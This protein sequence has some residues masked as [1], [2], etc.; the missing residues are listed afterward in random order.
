MA[1]AVGA[2]AA[3]L[4][5]A[6]GRLPLV[7]M[8]E[9]K[10]YDQRVRWAA[11]PAKASQ[12]IVMVTIDEVSV[13]RLD[14]LVGRWPWPRLVHADVI[15]FLA[16]AGARTI[17]FDVLFTERDR[18]TGF[19][20]GSTIW[21]GQESDRAFAASVAKAGNVV[22]LADATFEGLVG[23]PKG[24]PP[25]SGPFEARPDV[26]LPYDEL[27]RAARLIGHNYF[28]LDS[29][30]PVRRAVTFIDHGGRLVPSLS[31]A[32]WMVAASLDPASARPGGRGVIVGSHDIPLVTD[33]LPAFDKREPRRT[34]R[35][36]LIDFRGPAV[37]EDGRR[38][39]YKQYS[40]Y[41]LFY[42]R[43]EQL[44]GAAPSISPALFR[45]KIVVIGT[46]AAGLHDVFAV[47]FSSGG[48][49]PGPQIHASVID[50]LLSSRF[51]EPAPK[52]LGTTLMV[53]ASIVT[54]FLIVFLPL[55]WAGP[56]AL[57]LLST[58]VAVAFQAFTHGEWWPLAQ[59]GIAWITA[60]VGGLGYQ[61]FVEGRDKRAV[62]RLF[63]RYLSPDVYALVLA[64]PALAELGG[65]RRHMTV[66]FSD[67]RGFT[68]MTERGQ[69]EAVV[70]Q[71]N[72]YF[73]AMVDVLFE[74]RG[75]L[76]K[77]VG[78]MVMAL[79]GAPLADDEHA[80]HAVQAALAMQAK[81]KELNA[82]WKAAGLPEIAT[83]VGVNTG[84]MIAGTI[85][86]DQVRSYTVIG[87]A[88]N[89]G[90]RIES[91][92][93]QYG[94]TILVSESTVKELKHQYDLRTL[95]DVVVKGKTQ[96]VAIF[97][98]RPSGTRAAEQSQEGRS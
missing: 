49:M 21:T 33:V 24:S 17:V 15:D 13:R 35:R 56:C 2:V 20:V 71:L 30:G 62:K 23:D 11:D 48:K 82:A 31:A 44:G 8:L 66:L 52:V 73:S 76:D 5:W 67:I 40:Y 10:L 53:A 37:L 79:F 68:T 46:T 55:R 16:A 93:K 39:T 61:Y 29:D 63:S 36:L 41:D 72:A 32:G 78:D 88:V 4:S 81:L 45:D 80:D 95:G 9:W 27:A 96:A 60:V 38:T 94:T 57:L 14:P 50:Q 34:A 65:K 7:D 69:P 54:A 98:V 64:N 25:A 97:E 77:F 89:L 59:P 47:P 70:E 87:D 6:A 92:N 83:G 18:R 85:G 43:Q 3:A 58:V 12:D 86:S 84:E 26:Q 75:T 28:V 19:D 1:L 90:S 74:H 91:L 51:I 42:A 22:V